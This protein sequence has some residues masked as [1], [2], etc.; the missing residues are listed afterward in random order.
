MERDPVIGKN[1]IGREGRG[2]VV[3]N[4]DVYAVLSQERDKA[5]KFLQR[6]LLG[7]VRSGCLKGIAAGRFGVKAEVDRS[8]HQEMGG[9]LHSHSG[10]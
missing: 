6:L 3:D 1:G 9:R 5:F 8:D 4:G 7:I 2:C 10:L